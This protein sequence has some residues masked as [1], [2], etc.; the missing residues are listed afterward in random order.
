VNHKKS[1]N[2]HWQSR[3]SEAFYKLFFEHNEEA[4]LVLTLEGEILAANAAAGKLLGYPAQKMQQI[5]LKDLFF[6]PQQWEQF[7][8]ELQDGESV[9]RQLALL[10]KRSGGTCRGLI[11]LRSLYDESERPFLIVATFSRKT[12][13]ENLLQKERNFISAILETTGA[14]LVLL[15][16][17]YRFIRINNAFEKLTGYT[18]IDLLGIFIWDMILPQGEVAEFKGVF[19]KLGVNQPPLEHR[20]RITGSDGR[21]YVVIWTITV[22]T[23]E[24][25]NPEYLICTGIDVTELQ[26]ALSKIKILSG[27]LPICSFCKKI[28]DDQGHWKILEE[29]IHEHSEAEFSH[30][31]CP[32]CLK[33]NYPEYSRK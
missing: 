17:Q 7:Y 6:D 13:S 9:T 18:I 21:E 23:G 1:K 29:Y 27:F 12:R 11:S 15:D 25:N 28:R 31:L 20:C 16:P 3:L 30:G 5:I 14:L 2:P 4:V 32:E 22:M 8:A 26:E 19:K 10:Q 33:N 24:D